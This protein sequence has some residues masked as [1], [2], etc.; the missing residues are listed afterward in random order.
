VAGHMTVFVARTRGPFW[1]IKPSRVLLAAVLGTQAV[2]TIIVVYGFL[3]PA[4]GWGWAAAV[5]GYA[6]VWFLI[7]DRMKLWAY[8]FLCPGQ[9]AMAHIR[10]AGQHAAP[11]SA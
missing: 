8:R 2:A 5:W 6:F 7:S 3:M 9:S 1:S 11:H 10:R 4:I